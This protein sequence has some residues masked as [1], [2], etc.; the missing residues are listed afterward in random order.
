[1]HTVFSLYGFLDKHVLIHLFYQTTQCLLL[2]CTFYIVHHVFEDDLYVCGVTVR[3]VLGLFTGTKED[4]AVL[5]GSEAQ[6]R[7]A[8]CFGFV[9]A[10]AER[11]LLTVSTR[12]PGVAFPRLHL[13]SV[14]NSSRDD[15][16][17]GLR[18]ELQQS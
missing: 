7:D 1:M 16:L 14:G 4:G 3:C 6:R 13:H 12:A 18:T 11:L 15:D 5:V 8:R 10:V 2:E 17:R 9:S